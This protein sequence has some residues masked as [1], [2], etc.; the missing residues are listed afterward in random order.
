MPAVKSML[1]PS[2]A[3]G[4][5]VRLGG[6]VGGVG[7]WR[8]RL[9]IHPDNFTVSSVIGR[10]KGLYNGWEPLPYATD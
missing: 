3:R 2:N 6:G 9:V 4:V 1:V 7:A 5:S 10:K 8:P